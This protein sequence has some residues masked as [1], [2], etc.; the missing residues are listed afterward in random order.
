MLRELFPL[1]CLQ[2]APAHSINKITILCERIS[3]GIIIVNI[4]QLAQNL[5]IT[6]ATINPKHIQ[7]FATSSSLDFHSFQFYDPAT[8][9]KIVFSI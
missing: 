9:V 3:K 2:K 4:M 1:E 7:S 5:V 6:F 8:S